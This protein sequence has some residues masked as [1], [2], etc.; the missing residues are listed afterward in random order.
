MSVVFIVHTFVTFHSQILPSERMGSWYTI[1]MMNI[2]F[3][4]EDRGRSFLRTIRTLYFISKDAELFKVTFSSSNSN[5]YTKRIAGLSSRANYTDQAARGC[6]VV[7]ATYPYG[8]ILGFLDWS[9][10]YFSQVATKLYSRGWV[11]TVPDLLLLR[12]SGSAGNRTRDLWI[13]SQEHWPL[14]HR[15]VQWCE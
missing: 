13:C 8:R 5:I 3:H 4:P 9:R 2:I 10:Y 15:D 14:D 12:K 11:D 7:S 6:R 1:T